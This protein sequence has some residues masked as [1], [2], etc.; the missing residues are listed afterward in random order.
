MPAR[1]RVQTRRWVAG[2]IIA[3]FFVAVAGSAAIGWWYARE[4]PPHQGPI[5]LVSMDGVPATDLSA[6]GAQRSDTPAL[7]ALANESVVFERAYTHSP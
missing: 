4:S 3:L 6:Y 1:A 5:L 2:L 7:D